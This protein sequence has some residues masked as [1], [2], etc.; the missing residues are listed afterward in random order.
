MIVLGGAVS[1]ATNVANTIAQIVGDPALGEVVS[2]A[3]QIYA[4]QTAT[5]SIG[6]KTPP[7]P[8]GPID[9]RA[10]VGLKAAV[11]PLKAILYVSK[12]PWVVPASIGAII[13]LPLLL[14]FA[15]GRASKRSKGAP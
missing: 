11:P 3:K 5:P 12:N 9:Y 4:V 2:L 7:K 14:G 10:G 8:T 6:T 13:G 15:L 1:T